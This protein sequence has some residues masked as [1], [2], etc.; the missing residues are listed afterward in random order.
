MDPVRR[1]PQDDIAIG[2]RLAVNDGIPFNGADG[3]ARKVVLPVAVH[4][5][6]FCG[7]ATNECA[8]GLTASVCDSRY[9][10]RRH[11]RFQPPCRQVVEK[12]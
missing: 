9:N 4:V 11:I 6:H 5:G 8:T 7:L 2:Y 12:E 3:K 1:K 10:G